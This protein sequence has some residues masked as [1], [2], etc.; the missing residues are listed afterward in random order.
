[1]F[2]GVGGF[3]LLGFTTAL[4]LV[5]G[6]PL[7]LLLVVVFVSE[8]LKPLA[9]SGEGDLFDAKFAINVYESCTIWERRKMST[10]C[11]RKKS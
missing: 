10:D 2:A 3:T 11:W 4:G 6:L 7:K 5:K 1:M 9:E 8:F